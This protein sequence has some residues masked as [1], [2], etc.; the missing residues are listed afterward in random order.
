MGK[1]HGLSRRREFRLE[2]TSALG[3][4]DRYGERV[5]STESDV[6]P[7]SARVA[8]DIRR[9]IT[10]G[11]L[12]DGDRVPST[13][14]ITKQWG[15]AMA[16]ATKALVLLRDEGLV[17]AQSGRGTVVATPAARDGGVPHAARRRVRE[18]DQELTQ[19]DVVRAAIH[20][21][22]TEGLSVLSM[23][24]VASALDIATMTLYRYVPSKYELVVMMADA[25]FAES[26]PPADA[27]R[28]WRD[29][30]ELIARLQWSGYRLHPWLAQVI[31]FTRPEPTPHA[32]PNTEWALAALEG[33]GLDASTM[34][35]LVVTLFG[36]VRGTAVA[37]E[38]EAEAVRATGL[39]DEEWM[40][41][42]ELRMAAIMESGR[43]PALS[44][45]IMHDIDF[46]L[47]DFFE[48]GLQRLLDGMAVLIPVST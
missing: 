4:R 3:S 24:R 48:F 32:L 30:F 33:L 37:L 43:F 12:H 14:E 41:G 39:S 2:R 15:V 47:E 28:G 40:H 23:R 36:Y 27:P 34:L 31:S 42:Q 44:R 35:Y 17:R 46:N 29:R 38:L 22:D 20:I 7:P 19:A 1:W 13:R 5:N 45:V 6:L 10:S 26:P 8:A 16:T 21:A 18:A 9:R 25:V 11:E